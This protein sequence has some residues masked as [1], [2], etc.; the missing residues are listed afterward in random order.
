MCSK[1]KQRRRTQRAACL[2]SA[3]SLGNERRILPFPH[4]CS[5][6]G[7]EN[8]FLHGAGDRAIKR[9]DSPEQSRS[10]RD[11]VADDHS[12]R[13]QYFLRGE[14]TMKAATIDRK[15]TRLNSSHLGISYA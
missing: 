10:P 1:M 5:H 15:S 6:D 14:L 2:C 13:G 8:S 4:L 9:K 7:K 12:G 11:K 3:I